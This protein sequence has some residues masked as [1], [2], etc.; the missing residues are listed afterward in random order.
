MSKDVIEQVAEDL[1]IRRLTPNISDQKLICIPAA[2]G[3][4][5]SF[6]NFAKH[7]P[8]DWEVWA[9]DPPGH[10]LSKGPLMWSVE[11]MANY[12]F[13]KLQFLFSDSFYL[14]GHSLGGLVVYEILKRLEATG[15][16][17]RGAV[18]CASQPPHRIAEKKSLSNLEDDELLE[19]L[20]KLNG[21]PVELLK[22]E[23][24]LK[25]Y[26]P[27]IRNDLYAF[28][29]YSVLSYGQPIQTPVQVFGG[30]ADPLVEAKNIVEWNRYCD[31]VELVLIEGDHFIV[32]S[33]AEELAVQ[34]TKSRVTN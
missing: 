34:M 24:F 16:H 25:Q 17:C 26:M 14:M 29:T 21:I 13:K 33:S 8:S 27:L 22:H 9:I 28:E 1:V 10:G 12:Y 6:K 11:Q 23:K 30:Y 3:S 18:I 31:N 19:Q 4:S 32:Q 15:I 7:M 2:G 20:I 5:I